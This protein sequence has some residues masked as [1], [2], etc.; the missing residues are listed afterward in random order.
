[1]FRLVRGQIA[2]RLAIA[3]FFLAALVWHA[4]HQNWVLV[5]VDAMVAVFY[6]GD[7]VRRLR[8]RH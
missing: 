3:G 6:L 8:A 2:G 7:V 5:A 1:M 4:V